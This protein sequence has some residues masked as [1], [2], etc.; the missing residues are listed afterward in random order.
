[1]YVRVKL[2]LRDPLQLTNKDPMLPPNAWRQLSSLTSLA[3]ALKVRDAYVTPVFS[4][5]W[6]HHRFLRVAVE[7]QEFQYE[8]ANLVKSTVG[9]MP[10]L[11]RYE[12]AVYDITVNGLAVGEALMRLED[13]CRGVELA[14]PGLACAEPVVKTAGYFSAADL[15]FTVLESGWEEAL[16]AEDP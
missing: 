3:L 1:M 7:F 12:V 10:R 11:A 8:G 9:F 16:E 14:V 13:V 6:S 4:T 15:V 5:A 2:I